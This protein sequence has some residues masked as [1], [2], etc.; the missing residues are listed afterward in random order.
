M[1]L[2]C[3]ECD[4]RRTFLSDDGGD[5]RL[6]LKEIRVGGRPV[7]TDPFNNWVGAGM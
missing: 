2:L 1:A 5:P 7:A 3:R 6:A 4:G